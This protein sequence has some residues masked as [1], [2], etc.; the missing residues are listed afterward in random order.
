VSYDLIVVGTG[1]GSVGAGPQRSLIRVWVFLPETET[2]IQAGE[3]LGESNYRIH[4]LHDADRS[5]LFEAYEEALVLFG[6]VSQ[7]TTLEDWNEPETERANLSAYALFKTA[8]VYLLQGNQEFAESTFAQLAEF[9]PEG[10]TGHAYVELAEAFRQAYAADESVIQGCVAAQGLAQE[11]AEEILDPLGS[12][13]FG[14]A[15]P[16]YT[17][18]DICPWE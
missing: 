13:A 11:R 7:D 17:P 3:T 15:N 16:D 6:R 14:Y 2:W 10:E 1:F 12:V 18:E 4:V 5:V 8:I 9:Y